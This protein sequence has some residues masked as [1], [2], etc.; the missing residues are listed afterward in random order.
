MTNLFP[1]LSLFVSTTAHNPFS[2]LSGSSRADDCVYVSLENIACWLR[3]QETAQGVPAA[4]Y[5]HLIRKLKAQ[6]DHIEISS[7]A[8]ADFRPFRDHLAETARK[9][10]LVRMDQELL[11]A[12]PAFRSAL[13]QCFDTEE[14]GENI[15]L[16]EPLNIARRECVG[17]VA[18]GLL[19]FGNGSSH[20]NFRRCAI[21]LIKQGEW[22]ADEISVLFPGVIDR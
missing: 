19:G 16:P 6:L 13:R 11:A 8:V 12:L 14:E 7:E 21:D 15:R 1:L 22:S 2:P 10:V 17:G 18:I 9:V 4:D 3:R 20:V 5:E